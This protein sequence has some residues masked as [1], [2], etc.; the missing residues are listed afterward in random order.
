[1]SQSTLIVGAIV[2]AWFFWITV[3]GEL[4]TYLGVLGFGGLTGDSGG[5]V[6]AGGFGNV[7]NALTGGVKLGG[8]GS[9]LPGFAGGDATSSPVFGGAAEGGLTNIIS[10]QIDFGGGL[11]P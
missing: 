7:V 2:I 6:P 11:G 8:G 5:N 4:G 9:A 1:M 3:K 10:G